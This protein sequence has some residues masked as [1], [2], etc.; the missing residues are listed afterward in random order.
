MNAFGI[1]QSSHIMSMRATHPCNTLFF[2]FF[3]TS[4]FGSSGAFNVFMYG[5]LEGCPL[6]AMTCLMTSRPLHL[7]TYM[8]WK[9]MASYVILMPKL[10]PKLNYGLS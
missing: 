6:K 10:M 4:T 7:R 9:R 1:R 8:C 5:C 3:Y 2:H